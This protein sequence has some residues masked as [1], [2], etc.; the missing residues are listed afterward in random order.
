MG[1]RLT[2]RRSGNGNLDPSMSGEQC[3]ESGTVEMEERS[4]GSFGPPFIPPF[5]V[6]GGI[7]E[8]SRNGS[9]ST[10][11][12]PK[13]GF[14]SMNHLGSSEID[15]LKTHPPSRSESTLTEARMEK[16]DGTEGEESDDGDSADSESQLVKKS[17]FRRLNPFHKGPPPPIPKHDA[18]LVP[19]MTASW[20][21][22]LTWGWISPLM[23]VR[24]PLLSP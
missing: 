21:S 24:F 1:K 20:F 6:D 18:G 11:G 15:L 7:T 4:S 10:L 22:K 17:W 12:L 5:A 19:E 14:P 3:K 16:V 9:F 8:L 2:K 13:S 23:M